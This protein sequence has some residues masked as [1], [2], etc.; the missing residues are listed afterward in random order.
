MKK[1]ENNSCDNRRRKKSAES[2]LG[3][4]SI[5]ERSWHRLAAV[6]IMERKGSIVRP[7]MGVKNPSSWEKKGRGRPY[8]GKKGTLSREEKRRKKSWVARWKGK[9]GRKGEVSLTLG[10]GGGVS[11]IAWRKKEASSTPETGGGEKGRNILQEKGGGRKRLL[12][13]RSLNAKKNRAIF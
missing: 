13:R 11:F 1:R 10:R 4:E 6:P 8:G 7:G 3:A 9:G 12:S 5:P 2:R